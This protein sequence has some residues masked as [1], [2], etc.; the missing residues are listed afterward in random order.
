M[1]ARARP[2]ARRRRAHA[3]PPGARVGAAQRG[4]DPGDGGDPHRAHGGVG[5]RRGRAAHRGGARVVHGRAPGVLLADGRITAGFGRERVRSLRLVSTGGAS[6]SPAFVD[7]TSEAFGC[8]VKRTYGSTEAPTV[9]TSGPD[10]SVERA[11]DTDGRALGDVE[12]EVHDPETSVRLGPGVVGEIWLRGPEMFAGYADRDA[13]ARVLSE[14]GAVVP[15]RRPR[16][17]RRGGVAPG[18][19]PALGHH[20]P[21]RGEHLGLGGRGRPRGPSRH[22]PR[23]G[24][25]RAGSRGGRARGRLRGGDRHPSTSPPAGRG[26][27]PGA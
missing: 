20:H 7:A 2:R 10:D 8:R 26:S 18:G 19:G 24:R 23:R 4:A 17:A 11:R 21:G 16:G 1:V 15:H 6:V 22:P 13:T 25:G 12:L 5:P 3:R 27:R 14:P 9:T